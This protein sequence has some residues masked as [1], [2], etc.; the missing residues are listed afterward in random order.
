MQGEHLSGPLSSF[1]RS[2][3]GYNFT[4][5]SFDSLYQSSIGDIFIMHFLKRSDTI[6]YAFSEEM[7]GGG[8]GDEFSLR[9]IIFLLHGLLCV[10]Q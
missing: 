1:A 3:F 4:G 9:F 5:F 8:G 10:F 6:F 2:P 7:A